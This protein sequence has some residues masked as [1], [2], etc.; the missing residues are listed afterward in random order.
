MRVSASNRPIGDITPPTGKPVYNPKDGQKDKSVLPR[1]PNGR[2]PLP[3]GTKKPSPGPTGA[4]FSGN[5]RFE[6]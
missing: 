5:D 3:K 6:H 2:K 4:A 1:L